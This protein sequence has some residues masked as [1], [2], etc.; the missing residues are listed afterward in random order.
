MVTLIGVC[1]DPH[2]NSCTDLTGELFFEMSIVFVLVRK[3][4]EVGRKWVK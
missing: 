1:G 2:Y 4:H 3:G